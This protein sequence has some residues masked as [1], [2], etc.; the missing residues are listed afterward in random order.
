MVFIYFL[1]ISFVG[2]YTVDTGIVTV[3]NVTGDGDYLVRR[4]I[5]YRLI[6]NG[7]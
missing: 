5:W 4:P 1:I 3:L 7:L 6:G 2:L